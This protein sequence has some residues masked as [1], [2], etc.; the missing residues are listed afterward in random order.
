MEPVIANKEQ[1]I[2]PDCRYTS[3]FDLM[4]Q[5][6][7]LIATVFTLSLVFWLIVIFAVKAVQD[8]YAKAQVAKDPQSSWKHIINED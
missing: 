8:N 3:H 5:N 4:S 7:S 6:S 1:A 2:C